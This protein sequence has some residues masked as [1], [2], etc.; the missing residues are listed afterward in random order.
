LAALARGDMKTYVTLF[1]PT[2]PLARLIFRTP[3][4]YYKSGIV[5][6]AWLN[7]H[8]DH[9]VMVAGA[10]SMRSLPDYTAIFK[11]AD[12]AGLLSKPALAVKRMNCLL[13]LYGA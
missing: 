1:A 8:Q 5:F 9:F 11:L 12:Q 7:G 10:Q 13:K 4:Q 3:T 2:I 6:L